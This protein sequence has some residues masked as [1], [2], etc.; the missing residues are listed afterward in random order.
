M[1]LEFVDFLFSLLINFI[2][3]FSTAKIA[4][5]RD[6]VEQVDKRL[7]TKEKILQTLTT[8]GV[9]IRGNWVV[10]SEILY[11]EKTWSTLNGVPAEFMCRARD[12]IVSSNFC[13]NLID[14]LWI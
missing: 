10:Q 1:A 7:Y 8:V 5:F 4:S 14:W 13:L 6:I 3:P 2:I 11:P 9:L 12:Y